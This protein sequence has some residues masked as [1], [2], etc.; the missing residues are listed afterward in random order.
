VNAA[1]LGLVIRMARRKDAPIKAWLP[2]G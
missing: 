2:M 1:A